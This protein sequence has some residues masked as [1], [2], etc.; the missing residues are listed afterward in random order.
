MKVRRW[1]GSHLQLLITGLLSL[2]LCVQIA[3]MGYNSFLF[4]F[5]ENGNTIRNR[6]CAMTQVACSPGLSIDS[7]NA[8]EPLCKIQSF[9]LKPNGGRATL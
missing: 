8:R 7:M 9:R 2:S 3:S 1:Q 6:N 4:M 5:K